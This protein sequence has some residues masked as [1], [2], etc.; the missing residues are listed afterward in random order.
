MID[1][2]G[3]DEFLANHGRHE[4]DLDDCDGTTCTEAFEDAKEQA[5]IDRAD[6]DRED[7]AGDRW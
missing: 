4:C 1:L 6:A 3:L 5:A 7:R 2:S